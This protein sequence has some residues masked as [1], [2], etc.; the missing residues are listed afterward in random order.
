VEEVV[1]ATDDKDYAAKYNSPYATC[2]NST[3]DATVISV[4]KGANSKIMKQDDCYIIKVGDCKDNLL[5]AERFV[6]ELIDQLDYK[7]L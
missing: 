2:A 6:I 3:K 5:V 1:G 4:I 7:K